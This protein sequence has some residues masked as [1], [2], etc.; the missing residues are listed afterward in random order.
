MLYSFTVRAVPY[1]YTGILMQD[2]TYLLS[3]RKKGHTNET[4]DCL[5][6][7]KAVPEK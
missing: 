2:V 1:P 5:C 7:Y 3:R 6:L 4:A